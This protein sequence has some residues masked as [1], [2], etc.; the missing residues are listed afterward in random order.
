MLDIYPP[1]D[2]LDNLL[3]PKKNMTKT[4]TNLC[5]EVGVLLNKKESRLCKTYQKSF[6]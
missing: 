6:K 1:N 3:K 4:E 5:R 2:Q